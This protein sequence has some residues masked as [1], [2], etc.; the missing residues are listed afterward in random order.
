METKKTVKKPSGFKEGLKRC[1]KNFL[2]FLKKKYDK[3]MKLPKYVRIITYV[4]LIVLLLL[5]I[6]VFGSIINN[7]VQAKYKNM[8]DKMAAAATKFAE[9]NSVYG[10]PD[11]KNKVNL[12]LLIDRKYMSE[13]DRANKT[14]TGYVIVYFNDEDQKIESKPYI[15]CKKY[16][17]K[18]YKDYVD[19]DMEMIKR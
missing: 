12:E 6:I 11:S 19:I 15:N 13:E 1:W 2:K 4:W 5:I 18:D 3:F 8:E 10:S 9:E 16:T 14:C 17:T 7:N